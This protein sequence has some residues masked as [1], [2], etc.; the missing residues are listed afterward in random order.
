MQKP[1]HITK[2]VL[3][4]RFL[5]SL[6]MKM[7]AVAGLLLILSFAICSATLF[8]LTRRMLQDNVQTIVS[9]DSRY[10]STL[11]QGILPN[12]NPANKQQLSQIAH[13]LLKK[14]E[15]LAIAVLDTHHR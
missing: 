6:G 15:I 12:L 13:D 10:L 14:P 5:S 1:F 9:D 8:Y 2:P 11:S 3:R 4:T 7:L